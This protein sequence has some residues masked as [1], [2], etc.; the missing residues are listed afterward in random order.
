MKRITQIQKF[1]LY[2]GIFL[3]AM[4]F[5]SCSNDDDIN[6]IVDVTN[7]FPTGF[8]WI[9]D[10]QS[11]SGNILTVP[12]VKVGQDSW[13]AAVPKGE[14]ISNNFIAQPVMVEK[15]TTSNVQLTFEE[16]V[17][18]YTQKYAE[19]VLKLYA[20]N[21]NAG[22]RGEWDEFDKPIALA[23]NVLVIKTIVIMA[24]LTDYIPFR[25]YFDRNGDGT[26][27]LQEFSETYP[28]YFYE[29]WDMDGDGYLDREEFYNTHFL[30]ADFDWDN[31]ISPGEWNDGYLRMFGN[32]ADKDFA[33]NDEDKNGKLSKDEWNKIFE[34]SD[35]F[36]TYDADSNNFVTQIELNKGFFRDW[37]L[38]GDGKID[39]DEYNNYY[40][41]VINWNYGYWGY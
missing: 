4:G 32:W 16:S 36:E 41:Y 21:Q 30:N 11:L 24:D 9:D 6:E 1:R 27:D 15:G 23:N 10:W 33:P 14:E 19:V 39:E 35:W 17:V 8:I 31:S 38:N 18:N 34:E 25:H 20:D 7:G 5:T 29:I 37:D 12:S 13:L 26:L 28:S 2:A 3:L 40:P 22:I